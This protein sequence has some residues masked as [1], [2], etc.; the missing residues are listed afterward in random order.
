MPDLLNEREA[1]G[2]LRLARHTLRDWRSEGRGPRFI[3]LG[4]GKRASI[5]YDLSDLQSFIEA[6]RTS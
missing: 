1:A 3:R 6:G 4:S 5:R 2:L